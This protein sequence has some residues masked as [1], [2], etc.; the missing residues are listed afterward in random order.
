MNNKRMR[1]SLGPS[2]QN[3]VR[4]AVITAIAGTHAP[5]YSQAVP[6]SIKVD[7]TLT[8]AGA[9]PVGNIGGVYTLDGTKGVKVGINQFYLSLI[10]I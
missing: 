4:I 1:T 2:V 8:S 7:S 9:G 6:T 5:A 10:H 3:L